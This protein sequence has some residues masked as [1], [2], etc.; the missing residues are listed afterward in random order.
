MYNKMTAIGNVGTDPEMRY[1]PSGNAVTSFRIA[2]GRSYTTREGERRDET[3]W[4]TVTAWSR[5]AETCNQFVV[6]GMRIYVEGRLKS[7][8]WVA[9]DGQTRF[10]NEIVA[11][12]VKFLSRPQQDGG[13]GG[14]RTQEG[15]SEYGGGGYGGSGYSGGGEYG[16]GRGG[17]GGDAPPDDPSDEDG[18]PW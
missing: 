2:T 3:E 10:R 11:Q 18:L 8:S 13:Y 17:Y 5:L 9:N 15:G 7:S 14:G 6:K 4:F 16:G 1:T 12:E